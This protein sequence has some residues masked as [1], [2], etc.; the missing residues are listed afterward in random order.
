MN[1]IFNVLLEVSQICDVSGWPY[2]CK[3]FLNG[4]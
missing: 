1:N 4:I 2:D 3:R